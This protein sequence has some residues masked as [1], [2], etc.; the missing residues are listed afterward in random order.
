MYT[1]N[2]FQMRETSSSTGQESWQ[3]RTDSGEIDK[4][5][6]INQYRRYLDRPRALAK[7]LAG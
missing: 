7:D 5:A 4:R 6:T 3:E 2:N 1:V